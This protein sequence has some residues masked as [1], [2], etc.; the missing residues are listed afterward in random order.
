MESWMSNLPATSQAIDAEVLAQYRRCAS[1]REVERWVRHELS[2]LVTIALETANPA[3]REAWF[4]RVFANLRLYRLAQVGET[5]IML[6]SYTSP[7]SAQAAQIEVLDILTEHG[8]W[9]RLC[10]L[11]AGTYEMALHRLRAM[12]MMGSFFSTSSDEYVTRFC[13]EYARFSEPQAE[14]NAA[15]NWLPLLLSLRT[16]LKA[17][18]LVGTII[19]PLP[20]TDQHVVALPQQAL[21]RPLFSP[22]RDRL[23][24]FGAVLGLLVVGG[25]VL[26]GGPVWQQIGQRSSATAASKSSAT[27]SVPARSVFTPKPTPKPT[28]EI[29]PPPVA[30][31]K[32][33]ATPT[34]AVAPTERAG[35]FVIGLASREEAHAQSEAQ[36]HRAQGLQPRVIYSSRWSG[37]TPNYY[38]VVYGIFD[39]RAD[40]VALRKDLERRGIKT[41]VMHSGQRK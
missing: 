18:P 35:F 24:S 22:G 17:S 11:G 28:T 13:T 4:K 20:Q 12:A 19:K 27:Q 3:Q 25:A 41:Y 21:R 10:A 26:W 36:K 1:D 33:V 34:P 40:T 39:D 15:R 31:P 9:A 16:A 8:D 7:G 2:Q 23:V 6:Q 38:Q 37:L 14:V 30:T 5:E 29:S 32:P